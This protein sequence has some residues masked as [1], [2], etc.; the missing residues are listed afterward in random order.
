MCN[1]PQGYF[2][3]PNLDWNTLVLDLSPQVDSSGNY[4]WPCESTVTINMGGTQNRNYDIQLADPTQPY[5][6][7]SAY[8]ASSIDNGGDNA[9]WYVSIWCV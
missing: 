8:C 2:T 5:S 7:N 4:Y 6:G 3:I 9:N 1:I